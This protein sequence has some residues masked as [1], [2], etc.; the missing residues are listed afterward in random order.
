[1]SERE[2]L[3]RTAEIAADFL[4][5]LDERPVWPAASVEELRREI[6]G[7]LPSVPI[8]PLTVV[9]A[10]AAAADR[11][12][13]AI[14]GGRYFG[15][16]IGGALPAALA[17]D[18]LTSAWDQNAGLVVGGPAAAVVEEVA[19][20][21][22]KQL[23]GL[24]PG[25]LVCLRDRLSDGTCHVPRC[26]SARRARAGRW[27]VERNGL[28]GGPCVRVFVGGKRHVTVDRALRLLGLG[29]E[30]TVAVTVDDQ[31]RMRPKALEVALAQHE[32][33]A[34]VCAQ[35]GEV[36]TG[37]FDALPEIAELARTGEAWLHVDG[38]FGLWAAASPALRHLV[39]GV[40]EADSWATD[41]HK[42]LNVPY[43]CG[44]AFVAHPD[45]HRAA[46]AM[47]AEYLVADPNAARDQMDWTPEF[48]RRARGLTVY[49]A[50]RSLG[51]SGVAALVERCC[52]HAMRFAEELGRLPGCEILNEV[53]LNQVL[54]RFGD[55]EMTH[56]VLEAVQQS[57]E[58]WMSGTTWDGRFAIRISVSNWRTSD[59]DVTRTV[60]AFQRSVAAAG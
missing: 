58:A 30:S 40:A 7:P 36:N 33:P 3:R 15:F 1:M 27:D 17:A 46:M 2:L 4:D 18:W 10:L 43:D 37:A 54:L 42:W 16:V 12:V 45:A 53:V 23:F 14:P 28:S 38:A 8:D 24:P 6:G 22:L 55:D 50:L 9:E 60:A 39:E 34:I 49:A 51:T 31:G 11:G 20:E 48:S 26:C 56:A 13:V 21:W 47:T 44:L 59:E 29:T 52:R 32:G 5:S 41:A 35:A 57:G 25:D 19:G